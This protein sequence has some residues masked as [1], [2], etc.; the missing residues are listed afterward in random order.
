MIEQEGFIPIPNSI[1]DKHMKEL[2]PTEFLVLCAIIRKTWGWRKKEDRI[3]VSQIC[4]ATNLSNRTIIDCLK[5]LEEKKIISTKKRHNRTTKIRLNL[6]K[7]S[8]K[9]SPQTNQTGEKFSPQLVKNFH[10]QQY[11][12]NT[13]K[14]RQ[15]TSPILG[16]LMDWRE[17]ED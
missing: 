6:D 15:D 11:N 4:A 14:P 7:T 1:F 2:K 12:N 8:E 10:T 13:Y 17:Y 16:G 9:F 3:S 5:V